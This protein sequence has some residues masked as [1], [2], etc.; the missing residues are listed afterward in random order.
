MTKLGEWLIGLAVFFAIYF[1]LLSNQINS[2]I[3]DDFYFEIQILPVILI[4]L[5]GV[6]ADDA[7]IVIT[8]L[9][10]SFHNSTSCTRPQQFSTER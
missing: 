7:I 6:S 10:K 9:L 4:L 5:L 2:Q 3:V 1:A 8:L